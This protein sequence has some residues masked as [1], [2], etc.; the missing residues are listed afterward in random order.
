MY[1]FLFVL[2]L[3]SY[4]LLRYSAEEDQTLL[5]A[6]AFSLTSRIMITVLAV[7]HCGQTG[8]VDLTDQSGKPPSLISL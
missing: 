3:R 7:L 8:T 1:F 2:H 6:C 4:T 5:R